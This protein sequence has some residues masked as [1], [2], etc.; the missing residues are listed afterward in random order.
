[1]C[2]ADSAG[3]F[4][5]KAAPQHLRRVEGEGPRKGRI[6]ARRGTGVAAMQ[7]PDLQTARPARA[8]G[9]GTS[10]GWVCAQA[11]P[12]ADATADATA[13]S[14]G[15]CARWIA[16]LHARR[17]VLDGRGGRACPCCASKLHVLPT[18]LQQTASV[19]R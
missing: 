1:V 10:A 18:R 4:W 11:T 14:A 19:G 7:R 15:A 12:S 5:L 17:A 9:A 13:A 6:A 8:T 16:P 2:D 3:D